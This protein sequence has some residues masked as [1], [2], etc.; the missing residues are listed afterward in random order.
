MMLM[1][2]GIEFHN[3]YVY[4]DLIDEGFLRIRSGIHTLNTELVEDFREFLGNNARIILAIDPDFFGNSFAH[5]TTS[6]F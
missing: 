1:L 2:I 4:F 5:Y 6:F 3:L